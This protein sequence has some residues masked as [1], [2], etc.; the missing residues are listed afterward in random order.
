MAHVKPNQKLFEE[1]CS[2]I[3]GILDQIGVQH[4][5]IYDIY[6]LCQYCKESKLHVFN[7]NMLKA[8]CEYFELPFKSRDRKSELILKVQEMVGECQCCGRSDL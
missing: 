5:I 6:D 2:Q 1:R 3:N 8:I 7:V 4:P